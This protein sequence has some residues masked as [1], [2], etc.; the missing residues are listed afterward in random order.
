[1]TRSILRW[2]V[3]RRAWWLTCIGIAIAGVGT[4]RAGSGM[5]LAWD[6]CAGTMDKS[7]ACNTNDAGAPFRLVMAFRSPADIP[8]FAGV[9]MVINFCTGPH[10]LPNWWMIGTGNCRDGSFVFPA[11]TTGLG[12]TCTNEWAGKFAGG[13]FTFTSGVG[14]NWNAA[15][16][17]LDFATSDTTAIAAGVRYIGGVAMLDQ[18]HTV[19]DGSGDPVCIGC[20]LPA[21]FVL[22]STELFG[23]Q[24]G[25]DYLIE[26]SSDG[27]YFVTWQGGAF[28]GPHGSCPFVVATRR[29]T[30][31]TVKA[32]YR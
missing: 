18:R 26:N 4:A 13:G 16:L 20:E 25:E 10:V 1:M 32:L 12:A 3:T 6:S 14:G 29:S 9:S 11:R 21:C 23:F 22:N 15:R 24:P 31:G 28:T 27:G 2:V 19:D 7:F 17:V 5:S 8:D 30:W